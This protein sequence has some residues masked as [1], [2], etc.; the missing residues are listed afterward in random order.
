MLKHMRKSTRYL[1]MYA[2]QVLAHS[3]RTIWVGTQYLL[4]YFLQWI[5]LYVQIAFTISKRTKILWKSVRC[6]IRS[7]VYKLGTKFSN[8][9]PL[10]NAKSLRMPWKSLAQLILCW[11]Q[12]HL[13]M[14]LYPIEFRK[15]CMHTKSILYTMKLKWNSS[16]FEGVT[17]IY[18]SSFTLQNLTQIIIFSLMEIYLVL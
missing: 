12:T 14:Y 7:T 5:S 10:K 13:K 2:K 4:F 15:P 1:Q 9:C 6:V 8:S 17:S 18:I 11:Q 16:N 3:L